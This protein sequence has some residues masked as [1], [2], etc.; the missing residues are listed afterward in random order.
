MN[1]LHKN[2]VLAGEGGQGIQTIAKVIAD[3]AATQKLNI[4]YIPVFGVE[5]RGTPSVAFLI[6]SSDEISYPRFNKA[7]YVI[8]LQKRAIAKITPFISFETKVIFDSST[9]AYSD[10][11]KTSPHLFGIPATKIAIEKF[12]QKSFNMIVAGKV[13]QVLGLDEKNVWSEI[14]KLLGKKFKTAEIKERNYQAYLHG[15]NFVFEVKDYSKAEFQ[16]TTGKIISKGH[17]KIGQVLPERCKS[18]GIC[19]VKCPVGAL[20]F[21]DT[22]GVYGT[23]VPEIDLEK[24]IAC[25]NCFRFCPDGAIAVEREKKKAV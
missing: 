21:S 18:C 13:S 14:E 1:N 23:P 16:P 3:V 11:P 7:D 17:G 19:L 10:L 15:R 25:G 22:L 5:Q 24:C 8:I 20:K 6:L 2:I 12:S 4:S 9:I